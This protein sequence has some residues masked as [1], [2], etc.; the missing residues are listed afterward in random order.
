MDN[1]IF[2]KSLTLL[3]ILL[4]FGACIIPVSSINIYKNFN[5]YN[6]SESIIYAINDRLVD[7]RTTIGPTPPLDYDKGLN[8]NFL[9]GIK[10]INGVPAY[11]WR[12]GC[13][14]TSASMVIGYWDKWHDDLIPG[15]ASTQTSAVDQ[16][17]ASGGTSYDPYPPGSEQHY[18]DYARPEDS[19]PNLIPD[20]YITQGRTP[21]GD[22][23]M[24]DF[25]DTSKSTKNNYYGW[26]KVSDTDNALVDYVN[27]VNPKYEVTASIIYWSSS[28]WDTY[29]SEIDADRP[30]LLV[31]DV[32]GDG[33]TDHLVPGIGYDDSHDYACYTTWSTD[34]CW[35]YFSEMAE[36]NEWGIYCAIIFYIE[37][38]GVDTGGPYEGST[39]KLISFT[40][41]A[42]GG[43]LPYSWYWDFGDGNT[44]AEQNPTHIYSEGGNYTVVLT[45]TDKNNNKECDTTWAFINSPPDA[46][47]IDGPSNGKSGVM[48]NYIFN[49]VDPDGDQVKYIIN[50]GDFTHDTTGLNPSGTD[51]TVSHHWSDKGTYTIKAKAE[52]EYGLVGPEATFTVVITKKSRAINTPILN[53]LQNHPNQFQI[54]LKI[55]HSK[56]TIKV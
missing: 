33:V 44:S 49:A 17:I 6:S 3:V 46:P 54:L 35:Y 8:P 2:R 29:C 50:W 26:S 47:H 48:L 9:N 22:N 34:E 21:H 19:P 30:V 27:W 5:K 56:T 39:N 53:F 43:N 15:D 45:V 36:G 7:A 37:N 4:F 41:T 10:V 32:N 1:K 23:S 52:D 24:A 31:V 40:G 55:I 38:L 12:H 42:M 51:V 13:G 14:P 18:E 20:D 16:A 28:L 11:L 25:M